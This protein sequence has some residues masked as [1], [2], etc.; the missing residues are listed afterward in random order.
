M[1]IGFNETR[2][3]RSSNNDIRITFYVAT[4]RA[5]TRPML[6]SHRRNYIVANHRRICNFRYCGQRKTGSRRRQKN[7]RRPR[8]PKNTSGRPLHGPSRR[9]AEDQQSSKCVLGK[10]KRTLF[11]ALECGR[12]VSARPPGHGQRPSHG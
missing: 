2:S 4:A 1:I 10:T 7:G 3:A 6:Q 5:V 12:C 8:K 11:V 9:E